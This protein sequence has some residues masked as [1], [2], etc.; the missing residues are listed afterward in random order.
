VAPADARAAFVHGDI[1]AWVIWDPYQAA[2]EV[3]TA[4]RTLTDGTGIVANY[5]FYL[6]E[7]KFVAANPQIIDVTI[8]AVDE[9]DRWAKDNAKVV[10]AELSPS[11]G[12]P[13]PILEIALK[14][15]SCGVKPIDAAVVAEQH[16]IADTFFALGLVPKR[17][18]VASVVRRAA[19]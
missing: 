14:R 3:A 4:A 2:A 11:I 6:A 1:Q 17:V 16:R 10:A 7:Q 19:S 13:A 9:I 18:E 12:I 5:Q 15:Q 8:A